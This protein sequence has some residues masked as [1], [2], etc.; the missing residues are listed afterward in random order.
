MGNSVSKGRTVAPPGCEK[1]SWTWSP[2]ILLISVINRSPAGGGI[3]AFRHYLLLLYPASSKLCCTLGCTR[4]LTRTPL[5][6]GKFLGPRT[7]PKWIHQGRYL[8]IRFLIRLQ[9]HLSRDAGKSKVHL[10][11]LICFAHLRA[12]RS[13]D[14]R[15]E[16]K[17]LLPQEMKVVRSGLA[18]VLLLAATQPEAC[19]FHIAP[20][21]AP[22]CRQVYLPRDW[23]S[24][25]EISVAF[26]REGADSGPDWVVHAM[27]RKRCCPSCCHIRTV[28]TEFFGAERLYQRYCTVLEYVNFSFSYNALAF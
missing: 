24:V 5:P 10:P 9:Y 4:A 22:Q 25:C 2:R 12:D 20:L 17:N 6:S 3:L 19:S 14:W 11:R 1:G 18:Q 26:Q 27:C 7:S 16:E 15:R 8:V 23:Y 28:T 21:I 13:A